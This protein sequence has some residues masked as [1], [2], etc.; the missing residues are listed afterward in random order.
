MCVSVCVHAC[1]C[2]LSCW[3][4]SIVFL[5]LQFNFMLHV[6]LFFFMCASVRSEVCLCALN[7]LR[8]LIDLF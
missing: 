3:A 5:L 7:M 8:I 1:E 4:L 2:A 6:F